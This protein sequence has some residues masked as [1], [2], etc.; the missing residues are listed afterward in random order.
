PMVPNA[1]ESIPLE[2]VRQLCS[3]V[4]PRLNVPQGYASPPR[5]AAAALDDLFDHPAGVLNISP[6]SRITF[7]RDSKMAF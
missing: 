1:G 4:A 7:F 3:R 5:I 6:N 2:K